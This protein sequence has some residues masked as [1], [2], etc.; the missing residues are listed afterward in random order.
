[1]YLPLTIYLAIHL[2]VNLSAYLFSYP[3]IYLPIHHYPPIYI[4]IHHPSTY[5]SPSVFRIACAR[6]Q[7]SHWK[8]TVRKDKYPKGD[9]SHGTLAN[10]LA[11]KLKPKKQNSHNMVQW[12]HRSQESCLFWKSRA[13]NQEEEWTSRGAQHCTCPVVC[14][15]ADRRGQK[16]HTQSCFSSQV[17]VPSLHIVKVNAVRKSTRC[18]CHRCHAGTCSSCVASAQSVSC[19]MAAARAARLS[20][21]SVW[22]QVAS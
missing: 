19:S 18:H 21:I 6:Y 15:A 16:G 1:M 17:G 14:E 4:S 11:S 13:G 20:L 9:E 5:P 22:I 3:S 7:H 12:R 2:F 8:G 10:E